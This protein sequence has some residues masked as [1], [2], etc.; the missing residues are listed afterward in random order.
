MIVIIFNWYYF[1]SGPKDFDILLLAQQ[2][3]STLCI[4]YNKGSNCYLP[5][6]NDWT[7]HGI[8][9][10]KSLEKGPEDCHRDYGFKASDLKSIRNQLDSYWFSVHGPNAESFWKHEWIKHGTCS[11][12]IPQLQSQL[13]YFKTGLS[14]NRKYNIKQILDR[15]RILPGKNYP[16]KNI[17][18]TLEG[19]LG[20][21]PQ[22]TCIRSKVCFKIYKLIFFS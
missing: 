9:P 5:A 22:I 4:Q 2:W 8:W 20:V 17:V 7:I 13:L 16:I 12:T 10:S 19:A 11:V 6:H 15:A 3:G 1:S 18:S 21:S 14:L